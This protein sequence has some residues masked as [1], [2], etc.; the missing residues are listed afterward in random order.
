MIHVS[1]VWVTDQQLTGIAVRAWQLG[2]EMRPLLFTNP[3][4]Y[5][6]YA[7]VGGGF[8]YWLQGVELRQDKILKERKELLLEKRRR[9]LEREKAESGDMSAPDAAIVAGT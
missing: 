6:V 5:T 7:T 4:L 8:G 1:W 3:W 9:K 2:I